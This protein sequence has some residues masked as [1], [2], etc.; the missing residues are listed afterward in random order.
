MEFRA[1]VGKLLK[2]LY[3]FVNIASKNCDNDNSWSQKLS[4]E[5][6][7]DV[8]IFTANG[9]TAAIQV[10]IKGLTLK[11]LGYTCIK[12]GSVLT[13]A[14]DFYDAVISF[15]LA[16]YINIQHGDRITLENETYGNVQMPQASI[17]MD[18]PRIHIK[19][20]K[21]TKAFKI[22]RK[23][24]IEGLRSVLFASGNFETQSYYMCIYVDISKDRIRFVAGSGARF[25]GKDFEKKGLT[26][27]KKTFSILIPH[28]NIRN[29]IAVLSKSKSDKISISEVTSTWHTL[30]TPTLLI[31]YENTR[32]LIDLTFT[33][34]KNYPNMDSIIK[35]DRPNKISF[36]MSKWKDV[37]SGIGATNTKKVQMNMS[38]IFSD[39]TA[40][41]DEEYFE[42][43]T[44]TNCRSIRSVPFKHII[45]HRDSDEAPHFCCN[46]LYLCEIVYYFSNYNEAVL[47]F[48]GQ[49]EGKGGKPVL[50]RFPEV[51]KQGIKEQCYMFFAT[52]K[53]K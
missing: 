35:L 39:V 38:L 4:I 5:A 50:V 42:I 7:S 41:Y 27:V 6:K 37:A 20:K 44:E 15:P 11:E 49:I 46:S 34:G 23:L 14:R 17:P 22:N 18:F 16:K 51:I 33:E 12:E 36:E 47:E 43:V 31:E 9:G 13:I 45:C 25:C 3:A 10:K 19:N 40:H 21:N 48:E 28:F 30:K 52:A 53:E 2:I 32:L 24:F 1:N 8:L 26:K 29:I